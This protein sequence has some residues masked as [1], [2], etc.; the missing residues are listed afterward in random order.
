MAT[1]SSW[2]RMVTKEDAGIRLSYRDL[3]SGPSPDTN[4]LCDSKQISFPLWAQAP[5]V[6]T[7]LVE[8]RETHPLCRQVLRF[9]TEKPQMKSR[10]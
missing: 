3:S 9:R 8:R 6:G 10:R 2:A 1:G 5:G 4:L 7:G